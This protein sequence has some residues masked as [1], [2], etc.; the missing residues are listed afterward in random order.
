MKEKDPSEE[1]VIPKSIG[2]KITINRV[3]ESCNSRLGNEVDD[4]L[5]SHF[6]IQLYR[7]LYRLRGKRKTLPKLFSEGALVD[8]SEDSIE[9]VL[10]FDGSRVE[11]LYDKEGLLLGL[12]AKFESVEAEDGIIFTADVS[13][14]GRLRKIVNSYRKARGEHEYNEEEFEEIV[15]KRSFGKAVVEKDIKSAEY[16]KAILKIAY[17]MAFRWLGEDYLTDP[18]A[19]NIRDWLNGVGVDQLEMNIEPSSILPEVLK[20]WDA[21]EDA[22]IVLIVGDKNNLVCL[23]R[24]FNAFKG[25]VVISKNPSRYED[26]QSMFL[27]NPVHGSIREVNLN[28]ELMR[29]H[30]SPS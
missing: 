21:E 4:K 3:C 23:I 19:C 11:F 8:D 12:K 24:I 25:V 9:E 5:T 26:F 18:T 15:T 10:F 14:Q 16:R 20:E 7:I 6:L 17:E 13:D 1:H 27:L 30:S 29:L 28:D 2:G 22:H